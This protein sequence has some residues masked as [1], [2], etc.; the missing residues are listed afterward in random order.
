MFAIEFCEAVNTIVE[1]LL[2]KPICFELFLSCLRTG[3]LLF[4]I[5]ICGIEGDGVIGEVD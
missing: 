4:A 3:Q 5:A 2:N 1:L